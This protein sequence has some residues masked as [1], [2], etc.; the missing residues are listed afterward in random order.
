MILTIGAVNKDIKSK[1]KK[2]KKKFADNLFHNI[3]R[4]FNVI[5]NFPFTTSGTI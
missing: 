2:K 3:W 5:P 4:L 1:K